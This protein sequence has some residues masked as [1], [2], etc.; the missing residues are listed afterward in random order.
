[1]RPNY[2]LRCTPRLPPVALVGRGSPLTEALAIAI[3]ALTFAA[4]VAVVL[5]FGFGTESTTT[6]ICS[7]AAAAFGLAG[8]IEDGA[9]PGAARRPGAAPY[10]PGGVGAAVTY[11]DWGSDG[12]G[13]E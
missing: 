10:E 8:C 4:V 3:R 7:L 5:A 9:A 2:T 12:G 1:M 6:V 13:G 11:S